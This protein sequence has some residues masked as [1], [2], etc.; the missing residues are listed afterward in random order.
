MDRPFAY[1]DL[2]YDV[3]TAALLLEAAQDRIDADGD[4]RKALVAR[5]FVDRH[6]RERDARGI[7]SGDRLPDEQFDA[8]VRFAPVAPEDVAETVAAD[9]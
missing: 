2:V 3:F 5:R 7:T 9:D 8:I 1:A 6:L 4:A